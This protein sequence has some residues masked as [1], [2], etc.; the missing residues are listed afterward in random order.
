[1]SIPTWMVINTRSIGV[2]SELL[3]TVARWSGAP[4]RWF[5]EFMNGAEDVWDA[6][7]LLFD[8]LPAHPGGHLP[9]P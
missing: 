1:M 5:T 6:D 8:D 7:P 9:I 4:A 2:V 3:S